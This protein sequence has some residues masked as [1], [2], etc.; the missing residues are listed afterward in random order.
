MW[1]TEDSHEGVSAEFLEER[2]K[3]LKHVI[4]KESKDEKVSNERSK[5][6]CE[7]DPKGI[8]YPRK[9]EDHYSRRGY[10][11]CGNKED[12]SHEGADITKRTYCVCKIAQ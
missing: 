11:E 8:E 10:R 1:C 2:T 4:F 9:L 12:T 3:F 5:S 7:R 6:C